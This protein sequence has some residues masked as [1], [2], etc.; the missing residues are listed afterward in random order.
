MQEGNLLTA[1]AIEM[2]CV[3]TAEKEFINSYE[4]CVLSRR[5]LVCVLPSILSE[6]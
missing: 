2:T 6:F 4:K 1:G 5:F 3:L